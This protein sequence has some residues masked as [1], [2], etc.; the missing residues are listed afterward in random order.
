MEAAGYSSCGGGPL[1]NDW[2]L[3]GLLLLL[4]VSGGG[5]QKARC[6]VLKVSDSRV[7][8]LRCIR[9]YPRALLSTFLFPVFSA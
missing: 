6:Y 1:E 5:R 8:A 9:F 7:F 3:E 4:A 2:E